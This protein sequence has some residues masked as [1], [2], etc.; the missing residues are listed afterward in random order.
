MILGRVQKP[1]KRL[2]REN[3]KLRRLVEKLERRLAMSTERLTTKIARAT[4]RL[5]KAREPGLGDLKKRAWKVFSQWVRITEKGICFTCGKQKDYKEMDAGHYFTRGS[6]GTLLTFFPMNVHCQCDRCNRWLHGNMAK[7]REKMVEVY[8]QAKVDH[9]DLIRTRTVGV[10]KPTKAYYLSL[11]K[12][13]KGLLET[14]PG[15]AIDEHAASSATS[16]VS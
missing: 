4:T 14:I 16:P 8:G 11:I 1:E 3:K 12:K 13:Y 15:D 9:L 10:F 5:S 2:E 6:G 7:Y